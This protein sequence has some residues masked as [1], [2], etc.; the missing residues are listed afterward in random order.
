[1]GSFPSGLSPKARPITIDLFCGAGGF[2]LGLAKAGFDVVGA[3]DSWPV[4]VNT[5]K[6]NFSHPV[7]CA[8]LGALSGRQI[9]EL[10]SLPDDEQIDLI[11]GGPPCQGFSIQR[12]GS[13]LDDRN[14]LVLE[15]GRLVRELGGTCFV[16]EN[17]PGLLG[18]RGQKLAGLFEDELVA[19][20]YQVRHAV[21]NAAQY[22]VPQLRRRV[23][24]YGWLPECVPA[25]WLPRPTHAADDFVTSWQAIGDLPSP[26]SDGTPLPEDELHRRMRLSRLN[27]ERLRLIPPG[28]G[29]ESLPPDMRVNCHKEGA[30]RIGHRYVYGRLSPTEPASTITGRFDSFTR[31]KFAHPFEDRNMSLREGAR[32]QTFPDDFR[33]LGT[34]EEI[35]ALIGNA[36]P[37]RLA[38]AVGGAIK[39]ALDDWP[40][41]GG[42]G[43]LV[44]SRLPFPPATAKL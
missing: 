15:F 42:D 21:L 9:R 6:R 12:I 19:A 31:G 4:A 26:P 40:E 30:S 14:H 20:G 43:S 36:V 18:H 7:V 35:A 13:D 22:G 28:G 11:V 32:L 33:F 25:L 37:P 38:A 34:Q 8:D 16:M 2:S 3:V 24:F 41:G 39:A 1:M 44:S 23:F 27:Q 17:V 5:Y 29:M 10:L